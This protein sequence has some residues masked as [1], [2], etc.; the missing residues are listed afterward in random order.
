MLRVFL[1]REIAK[2]K[3]GHNPLWS[4]FKSG[5]KLIMIEAEAIVM[6]TGEEPATHR[7]TAQWVLAVEKRGAPLLA[8]SDVVATPRS[9]KKR[10]RAAFSAT[11]DPTVGSA[12]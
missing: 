11:R 2:I 3:E 5:I 8:M 6:P 1:S 10:L 7:K 4:T 12:R 9:L